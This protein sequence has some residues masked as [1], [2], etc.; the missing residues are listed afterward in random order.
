[1]TVTPIKLSQG[2]EVLR[3][4]SD[5]AYPVPCNEW[6]VLRQQIEQLTTDPWFFQNAGFL[7]LGAA[8]AT[9]I[10]IWTGAVVPSESKPDATVI[11]WAL[12]AV[13]GFTGAAA[14]YFAHKERKVHRS[15]ASMVV[16]QMKLIEQRFERET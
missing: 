5:Q 9:L 7:L 3:P 13:C 14:I 1:M 8:V 12:A 10:S 15:K 2:L 16:T 11:A 4:K 6:D